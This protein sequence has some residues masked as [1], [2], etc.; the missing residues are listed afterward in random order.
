MYRRELASG[1]VRLSA[2]QLEDGLPGRRG[3]TRND[4]GSLRSADDF[5]SDT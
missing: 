1:C 3:L 2:V 5:V 4:V